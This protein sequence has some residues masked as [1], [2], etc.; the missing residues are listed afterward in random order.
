MQRTVLLVLLVLLV[1]PCFTARVAA[2]S[3]IT[4]CTVPGT[5]YANAKCVKHCTACVADTPPSCNAYFR[6]AWSTSYRYIRYECAT[7]CPPTLA[8]SQYLLVT[9]AI[10]F[11]S[12]AVGVTFYACIT[13]RVR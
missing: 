7:S 11:V 13:M 10:L 1:A 2:S 8:W 3:C 12:V 9:V 4:A 6:P 5:E